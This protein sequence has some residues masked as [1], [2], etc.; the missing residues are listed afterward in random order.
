MTNNASVL[1]LLLAIL[2]ISLISLLLNVLYY[3]FYFGKY[4][5]YL[6]N[7][8]PD[9]SELITRSDLAGDY[10]LRIDF[11][12]SEDWPFGDLGE[13]DETMK[14]YR[15]RLGTSTKIMGVQLALIIVSTILTILLKRA[16][17]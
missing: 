7:N 5:F 6:K 3:Y 17:A 13:E 2:V 10:K 8:R 9:L 1:L 16:S 14:N 11:H 15:T 12:R 4:F